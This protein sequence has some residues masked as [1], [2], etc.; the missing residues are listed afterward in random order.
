MKSR[1]L[2][3]VLLAALVVLPV[4]AAHAGMS[5]A[6]SDRKTSKSAQSKPGFAIS[7]DY[8][9]ALAGVLEINGAKYLLA[10]DVSIFV[11][12]RGAAPMGTQVQGASLY[13]T[14]DKKGTINVVRNILVGPGSSTGRAGKGSVRPKV[15]PQ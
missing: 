9:G 14:G 6:D 5:K 15:T 11:A 10:Q 2:A 4:A 12:G 13:M 3:L 1:T 8:T 7:V